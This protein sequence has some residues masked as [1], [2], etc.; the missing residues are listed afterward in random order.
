MASNW[1]L[2]ASHIGAGK[3]TLLAVLAGARPPYLG[4][5]CR[6][7]SHAYVAQPPFLMRESVRENIL[8]GLPF[9]QGRYSR[10][11]ARSALEADLAQLANGDATD[12]GEGGAPR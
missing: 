6:A 11:V 2:I 10:C 9:H 5:V 8:F 1:P 12:V 3:S 4:L 7:G